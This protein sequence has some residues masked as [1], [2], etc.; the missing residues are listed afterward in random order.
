[1]TQWGFVE[2]SFTEVED[3]VASIAPGGVWMAQ[4]DALRRKTE[5][6]SL[7]KYESKYGFYLHTFADGE[8]CIHLLRRV[9]GLYPREPIYIMSDGGMNFSRLCAEVGNCEFSWKPGANDRWN[10]MPFFHRFQEAARV[11]RSKYIIMLEPDNELRHS[12]TAD[13][14][15]DA[16]G[17]EDGNPAFGQGMVDYVEGLGRENSGNR[18]FTLLWHRFGLAGGSYFSTAAVL[19]AFDPGTIDWRR[20]R[21]LDGKRVWSSDV[22][23]PLALAIHGYTYYPWGD[24]TQK[25]YGLRAQSALRHYGR[26]EVKPGAMGSGIS[27]Q[28]LGLVSDDVPAHADV[29]CQGCVWV[30]SD[31]ECYEGAPT[32]PIHCPTT[33]HDSGPPPWFRPRTRGTAG[34]R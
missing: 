15:Y 29:T 32:T 14:P 31:E 30:A 11:L 10:P 18:D 34:V 13:P 19:D 16:G 21:E 6:L 22:A 28:D 4:S 8:A 26:D 2:D 20:L 24:V 3:L 1:V 7:V 27:L 17:L 25:R 23:M 33:E 12:I 9:R 5:A